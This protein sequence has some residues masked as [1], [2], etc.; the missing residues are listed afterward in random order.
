MR[1][2]AHAV[3]GEGAPDCTRCTRDVG[4]RSELGCD[5]PAPKALL[6]LACGA[7]FGRDPEC[8]ACKGAGKTDWLRCA[9][10]MAET[11]NPR[12]GLVF[13]LFQQYD[14]HGT[15][16]SSGGFADQT[17][18]IAHAFELLAGEKNRIEADRQRAQ[19]REQKAAA[20]RAEKASRGSALR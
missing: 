9:R 20:K 12:V 1:A 6:R 7:C 11:E 3:W 16:P 5:A 14:A 17:S 4:L 13:R 8:L 19:Q 18:Q 15:L 2:L 10:R